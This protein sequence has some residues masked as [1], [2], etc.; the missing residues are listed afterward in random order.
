MLPIQLIL[1]ISNPIALI[2][3]CERAL[4]R[5]DENKARYILHR[6]RG[7]LRLGESYKAISDIKR[8]QEMGFPT[9]TFALATAYFL[10]DVTAQD[11][12]KAE[13]LFLQAYE[14]GV[15]WAARGL[16]SIYSDEFS[17]FFNE[18]KSVEWSTKFDIAVRKLKSS[19]P[20]S[21]ASLRIKITT[22]TKKMV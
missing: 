14:K 6:A 17:D 3:A 18:Q 5:D 10:G 20:N 7:Y 9:A 2:E 16:S 12:V 21:T 4:I 19:R 15:F 22:F 13:E 11:F 1:R 8:S